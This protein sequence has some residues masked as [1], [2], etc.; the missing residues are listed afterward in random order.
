MS[1]VR[2]KERRYAI[3]WDNGFKARKDQRRQR[4][5]EQHGKKLVKCGACAGGGYYD[6]DGS[7]PCGSCNGTGK[8]RQS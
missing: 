7:P 6:H 1:E 4:Y 8:E 5:L 2:F 3:E